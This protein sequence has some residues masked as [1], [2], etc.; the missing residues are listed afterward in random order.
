MPS[1][2]TVLAIALALLVAAALLTAPLKSSLLTHVLLQFPALIAA[3]VLLGVSIVP[4][5]KAPDASAAEGV[6]ALVLA[7]FGLAFWMLPRWLDAA[8]LDLRIDALKIASLVLLAGVPLGWGWRRVG[9]LARTFVWANTASMLGVLGTLYATFPERLCNNYLVNEQVTLGWVMLTAAFILVVVGAAQALTGGR[10]ASTVMY[11][12]TFEGV[13]L[14]HDT[15]DSTIDAGGH[16]ASESSR[17]RQHT[18]RSTGAA[19]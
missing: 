4:R 14:R 10:L 12:M 5:A 18:G 15:P 2:R 17:R 19:G 8:V 3:G 1:R 11:L 6:T 7:G 16:S 9:P 13:A